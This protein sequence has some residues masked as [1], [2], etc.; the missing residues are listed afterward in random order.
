VGACHARRALA[1]TGLARKRRGAGSRLPSLKAARHRH[2]SL[3]RPG[4]VN[5]P[6][7]S[8]ATP[9]AVKRRANSACTRSSGGA[10]SRASSGPRT[11]AAVAGR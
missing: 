10:P 1:D 3:T 11:R 6:S 4:S 8:A 7:A 9:S 5:S 2:C